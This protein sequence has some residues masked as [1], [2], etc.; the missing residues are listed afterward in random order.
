MKRNFLEAMKEKQF[1]MGNQFDF[2]TD[3]YL[4]HK[5]TIEELY[6]MGYNTV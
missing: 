5:K 2:D 4:P 6:I 1:E 3:W